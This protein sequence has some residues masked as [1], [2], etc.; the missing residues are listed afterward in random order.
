[1][2][3]TKN[4]MILRLDQ[5]SGLIVI[6]KSFKAYEQTFIFPLLARPH[7]GDTGEAGGVVKFFEKVVNIIKGEGAEDDQNTNLR[8]DN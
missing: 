6:D 8:Q 4:T 7:N 5:N 2:N 3:K 1:M